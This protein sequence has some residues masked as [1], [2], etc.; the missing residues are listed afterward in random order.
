MT[1]GETKDAGF[2]IGVSRT[3][4]HPRERVWDFVVSPEGLALWLGD[5]GDAVRL[6]P[7]K[8]ARYTTAGGTTGEVRSFREYDR[9]RLTWRPRDWDHDTTVQV[10]V[11]G[12]GGKT[13]LRFHQ[14]WL[15]DA[16]ERSQQREHWRAA[17]DRVTAA[18]G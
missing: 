1:V 2:Q 14:E 9:V 17:M 18:L 5:L 8:G 6:T 15:A 7:G 13:V 12:D 10:A 3:L 16:G 11:S 4:P